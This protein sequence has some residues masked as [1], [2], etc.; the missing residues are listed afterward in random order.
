MGGSLGTLRIGIRV[1]RLPKRW[2][3]LA[4]WSPNPD[5]L[6]LVTFPAKTWVS[7]P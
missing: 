2:R 6:A 7:A 5:E 3:K 1:I 4:I